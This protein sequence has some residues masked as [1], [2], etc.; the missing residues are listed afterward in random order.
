[1]VKRNKKILIISVSTGSG[2]VRAA[3]SILKTAREKHPHLHIDHIDMM[4]YVSK[5]MR[6][7]IVESYN[8]MVKQLPELWSFFYKKTDGHK[9]ST[10]VRRL[11]KLFNR[12]NTGH[13]FEYIKNYKPDYII[14]THFLPIYAISQMKKKY[15]ITVPISIVI[16]D[17]HNHDLQIAPNI[18]RYFVA[19]KKMLQKLNLQ[20]VPKKNIIVSG[21]PIDPVF[22]KPK[23][24]SRLKKIYNAPKNITNI[25]VLSGGQ[26]FAD[27]N[28]IITTLFK[29]KNKL[30]IIAIAG[31]NIKLQQQLQRLKPPKKIDLKV[32]GWTD[33]IDDYM[34]IS[35]IVITK[36]G[37][38]TTTEC[39]ILKKPIIA[40]SPIPGQEEYNAEYILENRL[41][42]IARTPEDLLYYLYKG[43]PSQ[44]NHIYKKL[45]KGNFTAAEK[46][47][48]E[49]LK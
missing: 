17:Y 46:I 34:R 38:L 23:S 3:N 14:V 13:F 36:P 31:N 44:P 26:G 12:V 45:K 4:D 25:L 8:L 42:V 29:S 49:V 21:I 11:S 48:N 15:G 9:F 40:I 30:N 7:T 5:T 10:H 6:K 22:Y 1:M 47:L 41:G 28:K 43:I 32:I 35:D 39:I 16:T 18:S 33:K 24:I 2:H 37:G 27:T 19:S 20:G